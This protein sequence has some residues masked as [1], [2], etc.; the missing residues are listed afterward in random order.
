[1]SGPTPLLEVI[2]VAI[3]MSW[4][5]VRARADP[6]PR[7]FL[8]RLGLLA[9]AAWVA[10]DT[11]IR[12]YG[13]YAYHP[14]WTGFVDR[15]PLLIVAIWPMVIQSARDLARHLVGA[16][17]PGAVA[18]VGAL[19]VLADASLIEPISVRAELWRWSEPGL[20]AV[21][22]IGV[23]GWAIFAGLAISWLERGGRRMGWL[24]AV[25]PIGTHAGLLALWWGALRWVSGDVVPTFAVAVAAVLSIALTVLAWR[26]GAGRVPLV[27]LALRAPAAAFFFVLL[28]LGAADAALCAWAVAFAPPYVALTVHAARAARG[29][30]V[31]ANI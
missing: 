21:P 19:L 17:G 16:R 13:F 15:V 6:D 18:L 20:F 5:A 2:C 11:C 23:I 26:R 30:A 1:M 10:E 14:G 3:V 31:G 29:Q 8:A 24:V 22:P 4:L 28:A 27:E 7:G 25:A 9:L 12:A